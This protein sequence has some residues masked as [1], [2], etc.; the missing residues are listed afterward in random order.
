[1][2]AAFSL[3]PTVAGTFSWNGAGT[4]LTFTPTSGLATQTQYSATVSTGATDLAGNALDAPV[5]WS[6]TTGGVSNE[7]LGEWIAL[8]PLPE[9]RA[10]VGVTEAGGKVYVIGGLGQSGR[11]NMGFVYDPTTTVWSEIAPYPGPALDHVGTATINGQVYLIGGLTGWP[12]PSVNSLY[13]YDP[14]SNTWSPKANL[15]R[16]LGSMAVGVIDGK[17]Y[18]AGGL[19]GSVAVNHLSVYDP[20]TNA[21]TDLTPMPTLRDHVNATVIDG[22][23][24]VVGGRAVDIDATTAVNERYDPA[25]NSWETMAPMPTARGGHGAAVLNGRMVVF[26]G[27][28]N[29]ATSSGVFAENQEYDPDTNSWRALTSMTTPRHGTN[30]ATVNETIFVPG[31]GPTRGGSFSTT[32]E[33][34]SLAES[35]GV[36]PDTKQGATLVTPVERWLPPRGVATVRMTSMRRRRNQRRSDAC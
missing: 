23:L 19:S 15:P 8:P 1:T 28:G 33:G 10:E 35:V 9:A 11:S 18:V 17:L 25:T 13:V 2:Q 27:E 6:F 5:S 22:L 32:H 31:G 3:S 12:G 16:A 29:Q 20:A 34:F 24:Y 30:G 14:L 36:A 21:W 7:P 26:G 4:V